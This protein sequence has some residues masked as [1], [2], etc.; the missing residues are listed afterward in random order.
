MTSNVAPRLHTVAKVC[1]RLLPIRCIRQLGRLSIRRYLMVHD[2]REDM[3]LTYC[4]LLCTRPRRSCQLLAH[5]VQEI[6][7]GCVRNLAGSPWQAVL[8]AALVTQTTQCCI[9]PRHD[10]ASAEH[11]LQPELV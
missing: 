3:F 10:G 4:W 7:Q 8:Q 11:Q 6:Q 5:S 9:L 2:T 1:A